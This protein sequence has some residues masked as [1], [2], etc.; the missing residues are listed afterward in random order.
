MTLNLKMFAENI[1]A[2]LDKNKGLTVIFYTAHKKF[3]QCEE[4]RQL[5]YKFAKSY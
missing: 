5:N 4:P 3:T 2:F 1:K